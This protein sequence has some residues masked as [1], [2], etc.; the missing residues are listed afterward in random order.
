MNTLICPGG[1]CPLRYTCLRF[2]DWFDST[3]ENGDNEMLPV[4]DGKCDKYIRK[5]YYGQ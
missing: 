5:E 3:D 4:K 1:G 2:H